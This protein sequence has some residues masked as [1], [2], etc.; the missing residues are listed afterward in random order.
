MRVIICSDS[1]GRT[2][3]LQKTVE[4]YPA[5]VLI[6]LGDHCGD[7]Y[8]IKLPEGMQVYSVQGN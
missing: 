7:V 5:D 3:L 6:H 4:R 2:D 1:H 8:K